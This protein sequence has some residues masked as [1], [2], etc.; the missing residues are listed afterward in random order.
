MARLVSQE[1]CLASLLSEGW[2][3]LTLP[4]DAAATP[5]ALPADALWRPASVPGTVAPN[6][7]GDLTA[8]DHWYRLDRDFPG[9]ASLVFHGMAGD[10]E[11]WLD[12]CVA[13]TS[14][15]MFRPLQIPFAPKGADRLEVRFRA[16]RPSPRRPGARRRPRWRS[17]LAT[18][19]ALREQ[20]TT[21]FGHMPNWSG[22]T[23][24]IGLYRPVVLHTPVPGAPVIRH[25]D[26]KTRLQ[27]DGTGVI[28][29]RLDGVGLDGLS[30]RVSAVG[31][32]AALLPDGVSLRG[33][34]TIPEPPL[35]W[36]HTHGEPVTCAVTAEVGGQKLD[37]GRTGFVRVERRDPAA[38]FGLVVNGVPV[39]CRGAIWA[40]LDAS[41]APPSGTALRASLEQ[42]REAGFNMLRV[43]G[44]TLYETPEFF[45]LCDAL[46]IMVWHD[47][48]FARFDYPDDPAFLAEA[49]EEARAFLDTVQA[50]PC[51]TVLCGGTEVVQA[52]AMAGCMPEAWS[53]PLFEELLAEEARMA[54]PDIPYV[55]NAPW[56]PPGGSLPFA[57]SAPV[58]HYFGVGGYLRPVQDL[59]EAG[60]RFAAECLAFA[61]PPDPA[62]CR[63]LG[64]RP[65]TSESWRRGV[66]HDPGASW[67]FEDVRDHYVETLFSV[68]AAAIRRQDPL[69]W[70]DLGRAAI[71]LLMQQVIATWRTDGRCA[72]ALVLMHQDVV[73][74]A[75]WGVIGHDG[76]PKSAWH[77]LRSVCQPVQV[78]LRDL[79][80]NG[81]VLHAIN[82]TAA[83][84]QA[85][86]GTHPGA[87][88]R[89]RPAPLL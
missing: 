83:P 84:C 48:M 62:A 56:A 52:A 17:Q 50:H 55:P 47:F 6:P 15:T 78:L 20:R 81:V 24:I 43:S 68:S 67:T 79:G 31:Y 8:Q 21:L 76:R 29:L 71:A 19:E 34:L 87:T 10:A 2:F 27:R 59:A 61:N 11:I 49:R 64:G 85:T 41:G 57:A 30:G 58:A 37:L 51:L 23:P 45:T 36:P 22:N 82:E 42:A 1:G 44:M 5:A 70:L 74:G 72:G 9:G 16:S 28:E 73:P 12:G 54:R 60:V 14:R 32:E 69:T 66:V 86:S 65:G 4:A 40:G 75:G 46:G 89:T 39:F 38:G 26:L 77:A 3:C 7:D 35:W 63:A 13:A 80:Q 88:L 33:Q 25:A 53:I 18:S